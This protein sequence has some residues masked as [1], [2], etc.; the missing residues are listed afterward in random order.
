M[1]AAATIE[2]EWLVTNGIGGYASGTELGENT[3]SYH[4]LLVAALPEPLGRFVIWSHLSERISVAGTRS[5]PLAGD[6]CAASAEL[7]LKAGLPV[8]RFR[9]QD[10]E[11]ER[12]VF[13]PYLQNT[14]VL[15]YRLL[16]GPDSA[17]L[18]LEPG[19]DFRKHGASVQSTSAS[20]YTHQEVGGGYEIKAV[21][22]VLPP[23]RLR[24]CGA[25]SAFLPKPRIIEAL[26]PEEAQRGYPSTGH[27]WSPGAFHFQL[28]KGEAVSLIGS[29]EEWATIDGISPSAARAAEDERRSNL[30]EQAGCAP[31]DE[32][33]AQLVL[34]ADQ[35]V[36]RPVGRAEHSV[37]SN[38]KEIT[39][40]TVIAGYHWFTD[41][42]PRHHDQPRRTHR[43]HGTLRR[44]AADSADLRELRP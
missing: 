41:W 14:V 8:W 40:R 2:R 27:L 23:C 44:G 39:A 3:R 19:F 10:L 7:R 15:T 13:L 36:I 18:E 42:G 34:A 4:G 5:L 35:F 22:S 38:R 43:Y 29:T 32:V 26:Y 16:G 1:T 31:R 24:S 37:R 12:W 25:E 11:I 28:Q 6:G 17:T 9:V 33:A 30:L 20:R 21:G